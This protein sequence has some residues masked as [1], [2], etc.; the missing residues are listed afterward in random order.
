MRPFDEQEPSAE[1]MRELEAVD[2]VLAG[3]PA[4]AELLE[5]E[6][7][8]IALRTERSVPERQFAAH[9][10]ALVGS[11]FERRPEV[12]PVGTGVRAALRRF[13]RDRS[14]SL[15]LALAGATSVLVVAV[16]LVSSGTFSGDEHGAPTSP[17]AAPA[18]APGAASGQSLQS[19][20]RAI[21]PSPPVPA[22]GGGVAPRRRARKVERQASLTL[23]TAPAKVEEVADRVVSVTD[24][25][26]GIVVSSTVSGGERERAGATL[27]LRIPSGRLQPALADLSELAHVRSRTQGTQDVTAAFVSLRAR[28]RTAL[29][30]REGLLRQLAHAATA[31]ETASVRARLRL[32]DRKL[33]RL[34][35][36]LRSQSDRVDYAAV[37]VTLEADEG[38]AGGD[39]RWTAGDAL[40]D[41]ASVLGTA[42]GVA[43]VTLAVLVPF[44]VVALLIVLG[45]R[46]LARTRRERA[47]DA[48][49]PD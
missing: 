39:G 49:S 29:A 11:G 14:R 25:Y 26:R 20:D 33:Q 4:P 30:E 9:L 31:N 13:V 24:R 12:E 19:E 48:G 46:M 16:A 37:A 1:T 3:R 2:A 41:A 35:G 32:V 15:P 44:G 34:H 21:A 43:V 42:L 40:H 23:A 45:A 28:V 17:S 22:S 8:T 7:L 38:Q 36:R 27:D 5:L 18:T 6:E 47:L 10:D